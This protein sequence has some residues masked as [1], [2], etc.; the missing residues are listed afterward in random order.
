MTDGDNGGRCTSVTLVA[1]SLILFVIA[2]ILSMVGALS[3]S[4]QV[5][6]IREF[7][8]EHH[9][10]LWL[11][12][13]RTDENFAR[14]HDRPLEEKSPLHC[15]YKFDVKAAEV[16]DEKARD[17][18]GQAAAAESEHHQVHGWHKFVLTFMALSLISGGFALIIGLCAPCSAG[19]AL[20]YS[21]ITFISLLFSASALVTFFFAAHQ[22]DTRFVQGL[23][24]TYEQMIGS[25][26]YYY[27]TGTLL[28][29]LVFIITCFT[30]YHGLR[31]S[32]DREIDTRDL[33]MYIPRFAKT[34]F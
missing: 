15:T 11:D 22:V 7:Q 18:D 20:V 30:T 26:F 23:V 32:R 8:A 4:W 16:L 10:G 5:V 27:G 3:P 6:D 12:C 25:A 34:T 1:I 21:V 28:L 19:C 17:L 24:G 2:L 13:S 29:L 31:K 9:H 33:P 14:T